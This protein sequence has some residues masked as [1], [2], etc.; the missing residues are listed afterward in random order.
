M[1]V[2]DEKIVAIKKW[3]GKGSINIFG[4]PFSG[5]DTQGEQLATL[6]SAKLI[7]GGD[8]LRSHPESKLVTDSMATGGIVPSNL[9]LQNVL[10]Y[11]AREGHTNTPLILS[12]VGRSHGEEPA[13]IEATKS[14]GHPLK[15]VLY[16][17]LSEAE[18]WQR[19][20]ASKVKKDR[21]GRQDDTKQAL[22][23][24]L[25]KFKENTL[26]VIKYYEDNKLLIKIDGSPST[27]E[28]TNSIIDAL[29]DFSLKD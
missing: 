18:I 29:Y 9:Y 7:A 15:A 13:T 23:V 3:L 6:L 20:K 17:E 5:K 24:R 19:F 14:S 11:L 22:E 16:L 25:K 10:P 4:E 8:I 1:L 2:M 28:V 12:A 26:P 21:I 27:P